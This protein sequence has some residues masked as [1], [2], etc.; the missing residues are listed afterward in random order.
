MKYF[1]SFRF[2]IFLFCFSFVP[3]SW[4][5]SHP[6]RICFCISYVLTV[7]LLSTGYK[8]YLRNA[9]S[10]TSP[11]T[12]SQFG[13]YLHIYIFFLLHIFGYI[14]FPYSLS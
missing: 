4:D 7:S 3:L 5:V 8:Y 13:P 6:M 11:K 14:Y 12:I 10:T 9:G 2:C 1:F